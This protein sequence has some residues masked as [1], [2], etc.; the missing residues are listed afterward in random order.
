MHWQYELI[1]KTLTDKDFILN[2]KSIQNVC[3]PQ[4]NKEIVICHIG[5]ITCSNSSFKY[6]R[7]KML[8]SLDKFKKEKVTGKY[9]F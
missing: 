7:F 2:Y 5:Y 9:I 4:S 8:E 1:L 6:H 3:A